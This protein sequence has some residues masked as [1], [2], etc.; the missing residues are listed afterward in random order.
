MAIPQYSAIAKEVAT[1]QL[2]RKKNTNE[3]HSLNEYVHDVC[4]AIVG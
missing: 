1:L 3:W 2:Q 4:A